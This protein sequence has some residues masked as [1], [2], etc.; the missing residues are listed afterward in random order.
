MAR[1]FNS[2]DLYYRAAVSHIRE[3]LGQADIGGFHFTIKASGRTM[4]DRS[5]VQIVYKLGDS[6]WGANMV[7][8]DTLDN[9]LAEM[10]RR[11]GWNE[12]HKP[13]SLPAP[14]L[15]PAQ[16]KIAVKVDDQD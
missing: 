16:R 10:L 7:E 11:H 8:G 15:P 13:L 5:E 6:E 4:T 2:L 3:T 12:Q 1:K 14:D 9:V